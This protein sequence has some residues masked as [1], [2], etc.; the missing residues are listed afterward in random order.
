MS[1]RG[2]CA[3]GSE[4]QQLYN[5]SRAPDAKKVYIPPPVAP[6]GISNGVGSRSA[7]VCL[8]G[9]PIEVIFLNKKSKKGSV[10]THL[11]PRPM[12]IASEHGRKVYLTS[13]GAL[14]AW[15]RD[16]RV[17]EDKRG[18]WERQH[19]AHPISVLPSPPSAL[20]GTCDDDLPPLVKIASSTK[21]AASTVAATVSA[22]SPRLG[23]PSAAAVTPQRGV[24]VP[25][26]VA[27][28]P[29]Q[30]PNIVCRPDM[31]DDVS[32][33]KPCQCGSGTSTILNDDYHS[34]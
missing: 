4:K 24:H 27:I 7:P 22:A 9:L 33:T 15:I 6:N 2:R 29:T 17:R 32:P 13:R 16:Y 3:P 8:D 21:T 20:A 10:T 11:Q 30:G 14:D 28:P 25:E 1:K 31:F 18:T 12:W 23:V 34:H 26:A 5:F 19:P